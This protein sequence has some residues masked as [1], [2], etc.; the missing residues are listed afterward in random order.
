MGVRDQ[1]SSLGEEAKARIRG[2]RTSPPC[3]LQERASLGTMGVRETSQ[4]FCLEQEVYPLPSPIGC[5][6][7]PEALIF[8]PFNVGLCWHYVGLEDTQWPLEVGIIKVR[9]TQVGVKPSVQP[10]LKSEMDQ[11]P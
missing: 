2:E 5:G 10:G 1:G 8:F 6:L 11:R 3:G 9:R 4:N 7:L